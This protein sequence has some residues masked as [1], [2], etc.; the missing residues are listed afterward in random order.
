MNTDL[1]PVTLFFPDQK[2]PGGVHV[3]VSH[4]DGQPKPKAPLKKDVFEKRDHT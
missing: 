3:K 1:K 2:G 4:C